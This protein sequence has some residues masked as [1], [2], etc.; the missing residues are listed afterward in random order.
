VPNHEAEEQPG[1]HTEDTIGWVELPL[2]FSQIGKG[3]SE[4]SDELILY[5]DLDNYVVYV[6][7]DVLPNLRC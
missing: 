1:R 7:F 6:G 5:G 2:E 3:F 4:V